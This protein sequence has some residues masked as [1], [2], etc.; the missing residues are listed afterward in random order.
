MGMPVIAVGTIT[1]EDTVG[2]IIESIAME[3][4]SIS[5]IIN[6]ES[7]KLQV[8]INMPDTTAQ[9]L[10]AA[11]KSVKNAIDTVIGLETALISKLNMFSDMICQTS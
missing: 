10:I 6:A 8:I 5:H 3:E 1:R 4:S 7:E 2:N 11:N 9:Q